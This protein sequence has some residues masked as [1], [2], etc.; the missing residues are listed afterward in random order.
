MRHAWTRFVLCALFALPVF[1]AQPELAGDPCISAG[2]PARIVAS[3]PAGSAGARLY[4]R[5]DESPAEYYVLMKPAAATAAH[6][7]LPAVAQGTRAVTL[8]VVALD[9][10]G[11][12]SASVDRVLPVSAECGAAKFTKDE[13]R[14]ADAITIGLTAPNQ[15]HRPAGFECAGVLALIDSEGVLR[16]NDECRAAAAGATLQAESVRSIASEQFQAASDCH[17]DEDDDKDDKKSKKRN[18]RH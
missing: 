10:A 3:L 4:F 5:A 18:R 7:F 6:A 8:R 1:A 12:E 13:Q 2:G 15:A 11:A 16:L 17:D 9:R 14:A